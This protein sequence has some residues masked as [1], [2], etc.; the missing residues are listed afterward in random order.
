MS[1]DVDFLISSAKALEDQ[2]WEV[3]GDIDLRNDLLR[4]AGKLRYRA[5]EMTR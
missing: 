4:T 2:A 3:E 5:Q 1:A